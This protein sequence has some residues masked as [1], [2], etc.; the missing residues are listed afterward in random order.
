MQSFRFKQITTLAC[1]FICSGLTDVTKEK[2]I[3]LIEQFEPSLELKEIP[4]FGIDGFTKYLMSP[5]CNIFDP[6]HSQVSHQ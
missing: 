1:N 3:E 5:E 4:A 2:C 6:V